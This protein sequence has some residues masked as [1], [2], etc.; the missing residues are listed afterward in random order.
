MDPRIGQ[1]RLRSECRAP[2]I[3]FPGKFLATSCEEGLVQAGA[4]QVAAEHRCTNRALVVQ[5]QHCEDRRHSKGNATYR[6]IQFD[7]SRFGLP[8]SHSGAKVIQPVERGPRVSLTISHCQR[9]QHNNFAA[10]TD[11]HIRLTKSA[12]TAHNVR[13]PPTVS[14][15]NWEK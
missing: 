2:L 11:P 4:K 6:Y 7:V 13:A 3:D 1:T 9:T 12:C 8:V 5:R 10:P 15:E 14:G